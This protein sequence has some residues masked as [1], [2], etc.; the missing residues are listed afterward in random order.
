MTKTLMT[1]LAAAVITVGLSTVALADRSCGEYTQKCIA[2]GHDATKCRSSGA[3]CR[4]KCKNGR[5]TF[6]GFVTGTD[7]PATC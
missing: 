2:D 5:S 7:W 3:Q 4:T 6:H 1:F